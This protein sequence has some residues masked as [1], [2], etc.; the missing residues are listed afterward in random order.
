[1]PSPQAD[2]QAVA[3]KIFHRRI[4]HDRSNQARSSSRRRRA[5]IAAAATQPMEKGSGASGHSTRH[6]PRPLN[7][8]KVTPPRPPPP[9]PKSAAS[10]AKGTEA[11]IDGVSRGLSFRNIACRPSVGASRFRAGSFT[12][13]AG[14]EGL[15]SFTAAL[16]PRGAADL[17]YAELSKDLD[18]RGIAITLGDGGD[19]FRM[20]GSCTTDQLDHAIERSRQ[21]LLQPTF[22]PGRIR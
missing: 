1:M 11:S 7:S 5:K 4:L 22:S 9:N 15:T 8:P 21:I 16:M 6:R 2:V 3:K 19:Y 10:F 18:S 20:V 12:D 14:K 17:S 13:P